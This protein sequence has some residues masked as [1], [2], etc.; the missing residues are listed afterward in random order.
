MRDATLEAL[1]WHNGLEPSYTRGIFHALGRYGV[2]EDQFLQEIAPY[3][4]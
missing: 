4:S 3:L 1:R 2:K